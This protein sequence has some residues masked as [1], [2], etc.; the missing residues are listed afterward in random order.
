MKMFTNVS[1]KL[2]SFIT[3][4]PAATTGTMGKEKWEKY[5][6]HKKYFAMN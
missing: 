4:G 5:P 3:L 2:E 6:Y 1:N